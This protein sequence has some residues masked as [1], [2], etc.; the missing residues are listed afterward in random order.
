VTLTFLTP[1]GPVGPGIAVIVHS[2]V[3]GAFPVDDKIQILV[4]DTVGG[5][6]TLFG[7]VFVGGGHDWVVTL[8]KS[9]AL[10]QPVGM[11]SQVV[12]PAGAPMSLAA[13]Q[14]RGSGYADTSAL[15]PG[16]TNDPISG[17]W[18]FFNNGVTS[19]GTLD[20]ILAAVRHDLPTLP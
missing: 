8:G 19:G 7:D 13:F 11:Q 9:E 17:L 18:T 3:I 12:F 10:A 1:P 15:V 20:E 14:I 5:T 16:W 4:L 6:Q 2:D